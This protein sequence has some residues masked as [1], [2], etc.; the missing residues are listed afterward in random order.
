M[1]SSSYSNSF[2]VGP[3]NAK[4]SMIPV[5]WECP[6]LFS[7]PNDLNPKLVGH[8]WIATDYKYETFLDLL[9]APYIWRM[10]GPHGVPFG[11]FIHFVINRTFTNK[12]HEIYLSQTMDRLSFPVYMCHFLDQERYFG[13]H[14][15]SIIQFIFSSIEK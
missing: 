7:C 4:Y 12:E 5:I 3:G 9:E 15:I 13:S 6:W 14:K 10:S 8:I 11:S 1:T 2:I